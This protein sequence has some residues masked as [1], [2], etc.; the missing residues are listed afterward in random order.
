MQIKRDTW[1]EVTA[2]LFGKPLPFDRAFEPALNRRVG[3]AYLASLH[4]R[5]LPSQAR[6]KSD[7]RSLLLAAYN[8][9]PGR[10]EKSGY[11]LARM[12][13][14]T[15]DYVQRACTLHDA[16]VDRWAAPLHRRLFAS[17]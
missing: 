10:L 13:R 16:L 14:N 8:A 1:R 5:I 17:L 9:G 7:E 11:D 2:Q 4:K 15:R 12:P 6:W 3:T